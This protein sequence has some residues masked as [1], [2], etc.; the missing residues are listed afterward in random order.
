MKYL[1]RPSEVKTWT[2]CLQKLSDKPSLSKWAEWVEVCKVVEWG[3]LNF[4]FSRSVVLDKVLVSAPSEEV[5]NK[6]A[7][8]DKMLLKTDK[9]MGAYF[10][11]GIELVN[12]NRIMETFTY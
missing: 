4:T 8:I 2:I 1:N 6:D 7:H 12:K 5:H 10:N 3:I 9:T 11:Q